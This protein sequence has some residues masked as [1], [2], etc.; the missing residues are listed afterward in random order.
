MKNIVYNKK[1]NKT[2]SVKYKKAKVCDE[3]GEHIREEIFVWDD[4]LE[5]YVLLGDDGVPKRDVVLKTIQ[6]S[7]VCVSLKKGT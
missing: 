7:N 6:S 1:E 5:S 2:N 4:E 3:Y